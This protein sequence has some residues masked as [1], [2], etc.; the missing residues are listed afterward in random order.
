MSLTQRIRNTYNAVAIDKRSVGQ[1]SEIDVLV[2]PS[3]ATDG[4]VLSQFQLPDSTVPDVSGA[5]VVGNARGLNAIDLQ[6]RRVVATQVAGGKFSIVLG[7]FNT[8]AGA[9][10]YS[11]IAIGTNNTVSNT[12]YSIALG[13][14]LSASGNFST[15]IGYQGSAAGYGAFSAGYGCA[16]AGQYGV[17]IGTHSSASQS[18]AIGIG[19]FALATG[20]FSIALGDH[21]QAG[22]SGGIALGKT[23]IANAPYCMAI[24]K[25]KIAVEGGMSTAYGQTMAWRFGEHALGH[26]GVANGLPGGTT[27]IGMEIDT[28]DATPTNLQCGG[29]TNG[30]FT[31]T[32]FVLL[33]S[34]ASLA[35]TVTKSLHSFT[36]FI[37]AFNDDGS[38]AA[39]F[40][41]QGMIKITG[42]LAAGTAAL[43]GSITTLGTD[44][45]TPALSVAIT[46]DTTNKALQIAVTGAAGKTYHWRATILATLVTHL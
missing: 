17:S 35:G 43:V 8:I 42:G 34:L 29:A 16:A 38:D 7:A 10:N 4:S 12:N 46:A 5:N 9:S 31:T 32:K 15:A 30:T 37:T 36:V 3:N 20:S 25:A 21:C 11:C 27:I 13:N 39:M 44:N 41:R 1:T 23:A 18:S 28:T 2:A 22:Q 33:P 40:T 14:N 6:G 45:N 26:T 24:N 19:A